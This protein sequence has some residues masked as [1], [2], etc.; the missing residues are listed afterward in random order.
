[1]SDRCAAICGQY[2]RSVLLF[3][4]AL[5]SLLLT[6]SLSVAATAHTHAHTKKQPLHT[7][8]GKTAAVAPVRTASAAPARHRR[9]GPMHSKDSEEINVSTRRVASRGPEVAVTRKVMDRFVE[10]TNPM[11]ILAQTTPGANFTSTD[12]FGLDTYGNTFYMRGFTQMQ[13]GATLD[14]IP[15][16]TQG[17]AN[18]N[19]VSITQAMIQDDIGGMTMSQGAGALDSFSAQN[20][21]GGH[22]V[23]IIRP[24]RQSGG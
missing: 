20:L 3:G 14:G 4:T 2:S 21:G 5:T 19:G 1:M 6:P 17:F 22:D 9:S 16:G 10:G 7:Q 12:A 15:M 8:S 18:Y 24:K 13:I 23:C 11:Q